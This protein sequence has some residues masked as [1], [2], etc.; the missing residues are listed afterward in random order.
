[1]E[2]AWRLLEAI[3]AGTCSRLI[4]SLLSI[5]ANSQGLLSLFPSLLFISLS[6]SFS[7]TPFPRSLLCCV[8]IEQVPKPAPHLGAPKHRPVARGA[9]SPSSFIN[10]CSLVTH[11]TSRLLGLLCTRHRNSSCRL[12]LWDSLSNK[13]ISQMLLSHSFDRPCSCLRVCA[14]ASIRF[15]FGPNVCTGWP[16]RDPLPTGYTRPCSRPEPPFGLIH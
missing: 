16:L 2:D 15:R 4:P 10:A 13:L 8:C 9:R 5:V 1:M 11:H 14:H 3:L 7:S 12:F 6:H